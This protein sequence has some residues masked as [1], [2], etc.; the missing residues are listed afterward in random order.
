[1]RQTITTWQPSQKLCLRILGSATLEHNGAPLHLSTRKSLALVS[2]LA[3]RRD[4]APKAELE[5]LLW[6][7]H[8]DKRA[9]TNLRDELYRLGQVLPEGVIFSHRHHVCLNIEMLEVDRWNFELALA[10]SQ[11]EEALTFYGGPLLTDF[12]LRAAEPFE[13]WLGHERS[14]LEERYL[15]TLETLADKAESFGDYAQ[16]KIPASPA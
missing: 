14:R 10:E 1:M 3:L 7:E 9:R 13:S 5:T 16:E 11:L 2:Y 6:P 8:D 15:E 4:H 12:H